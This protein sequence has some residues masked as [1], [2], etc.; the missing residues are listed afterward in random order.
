MRLL[1]RIVGALVGV[2]AAVVALLIPVQA[3]IEFVSNRREYLAYPPSFWTLVGVWFFAFV[4]FAM[5]AWASYCCFRFIA[6]YPREVA[7]RYGADRVFKSIGV[8][9]GS[10][11]LA[12]VLSQIVLLAVAA[13]RIRHWPESVRDSVQIRWSPSDWAIV[14]DSP[15]FLVPV[16]ALF[17]AAFYWQ[18]RKTERAFRK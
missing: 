4:A 7:S 18:Y 5:F 2:G 9:S 6:A 10:A 13:I 8:A 16:L 12:A 17:S 3:L 11:L 15:Y 14:R 1:I